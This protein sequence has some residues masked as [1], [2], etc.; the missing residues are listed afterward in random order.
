MEPKKI[1]TPAVVP[2]TQGKKC[3]QPEDNYKKKGHEIDCLPA[4]A[5]PTRAIRARARIAD[6]A[7][8]ANLYE[9][10]YQEIQLDLRYGREE[11]ALDISA[12]STLPSAIAKKPST[13]RPAILL[14]ILRTRE[15]AH[16]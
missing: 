14:L 6:F 8:T 2:V 5:V 3:Q 1:K 12:M 4:D 11:V 13:L 10:M 16:S 7:C 9:V 15:F